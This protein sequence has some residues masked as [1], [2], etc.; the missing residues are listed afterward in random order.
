MDVRT[1]DLTRVFY[2]GLPVE[3][4]DKMEA[5][6]LVRFSG[7]DL[8]VDT[9]DLTPDQR[10]QVGSVEPHY[11]ERSRPKPVGFLRTSAATAW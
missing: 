11:P 5:Y 6:S 8:I 7:R 3:V 2:F 9:H 1:N 4:V 10:V